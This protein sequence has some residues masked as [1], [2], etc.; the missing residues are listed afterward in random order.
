[1]VKVNYMIQH[2]PRS[3]INRKVGHFQGGTNFAFLLI[4]NCVNAKSAQL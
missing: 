3:L 4:S 1:M 2:P